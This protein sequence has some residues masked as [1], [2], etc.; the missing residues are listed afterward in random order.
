MWYPEEVRRISWN[1]WEEGRLTGKKGSQER[2]GRRKSS[3]K[4]T[5]GEVTNYTNSKF[6][7]LNFSM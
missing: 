4:N 5:Q 3:K 6:Q 1:R 7:E 2:E